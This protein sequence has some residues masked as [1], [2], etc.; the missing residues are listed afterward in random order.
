MFLIE[1]T[2]AK[3]WRWIS[4]AVLTMD[5]AQM[6]LLRIPDDVRGNHRITEH[7]GDAFPVFMVE[8]RGFELGDLAFVRSRLRE[9]ASCGDEDVVHFNV[10]AIK[11]AFIPESPGCDEMGGL[12]HWHVCDSTLRAPRAAVLDEELNDIALMR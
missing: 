1:S 6:Q 12:L 8:D 4:A 2:N 11:E 3:G 5:E 9:Q 7:G 10:Y